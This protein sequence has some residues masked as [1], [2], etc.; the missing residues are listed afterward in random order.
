MFVVCGEALM[1]V[2]AGERTP[3]GLVLD[4]RI[5]GSPYNVALGLARL[6]RPSA[7]LGGV[8]TD[9]FGERL[10][11]SLREEGIDDSLGVRSA[12]PTT[13]SVVGLDARGVPQYAFHGEGA[14]DR[15]LTGEMLP[16]LPEAVK[17]LQ[18]GSYAVVVEPV[19]SALRS[20]A[21][22]ESGRRV[23]AYDP[24]VRLNVEPDI[25]RWQAVVTD[26]AACVHLL[27]IS[28]EDL[29]LLYPGQ[30]H[31]S[32]VRRWLEQGVRLVVVTRGG[33][34][35]E[36][37]TVSAHAHA[38]AQAVEVIDTVGAGDT[39]QAALL[40]WLD[41]HGLLVPDALGALTPAQLEA[42]LQFAGRAA[43]ITCSRRG[44]DLPR[45]AELV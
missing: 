33:E 34:G 25:A 43:A 6:G 20:L 18:F 22:R 42:A 37:W 39:F 11:Q 15:V 2:Y 7:F 26:M 21:Q 24:N 3:T 8:S 23:V 32:V 35:A 5:G 14:A 31:D 36:A 13:L 10:M 12:A 38:A 17:V 41:E 9:A 29:S 45:R 1:D 27:K 19:G 28:D 16:A 40:T 44:A 30:A 4:A